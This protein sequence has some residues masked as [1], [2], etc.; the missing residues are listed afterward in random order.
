MA[1][2]MYDKGRNK[3]ARGE[4]HWHVGGDNFRVYLVDGADYTVD[5]VNHE[6]LTSIPESARVAFADLT[7]IDPVGGVCDANDVG[8][9]NVSGDPSEVLVICKWSG[10]DATSPLVAYID[11]AT[12]LP[13]TPNSGP[14]NITWDDGANK[15]FKL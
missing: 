3:F 14:I 11:S 7:V 12:G 6:F 2:A 4:I 8:F 9:G 5:L 1:N 10:A 15:I 13:V